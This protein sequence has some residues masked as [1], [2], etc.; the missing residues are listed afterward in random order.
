MAFMVEVKV[1]PSSGRNAWRLEPSGQL[2]CYLKSAPEKGLANQELLKLIAKALAIP[3]AQVVLVKGAT[4]RTKLVKID[5]ELTFD[6][7]LTALGI[8]R[9]QSIF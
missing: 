9:Q 1:V 5:Y 3:Q 4:N 8:E 7:L 2:K 6:Q